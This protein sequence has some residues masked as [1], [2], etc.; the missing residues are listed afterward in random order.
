LSNVSGFLVARS[1]S[2]GTAILPSRRE[3]LHDHLSLCA[4]GESLDGL[5]RMY[6]NLEVAFSQSNCPSDPAAGTVAN[7]G[8]VNP[9]HCRI[10]FVLRIPSR[11]RRQA[12]AR[13]RSGWWWRRSRWQRRRRGA[14]ALLVENVVL[15]TS[16]REPAP[17]PDPLSQL[18]RVRGL[19][20][21]FATA[22][23]T[24]SGHPWSSN[25]TMRTTVTV[26]PLSSLPHGMPWRYRTWPATPHVN[27][28]V[29]EAKCARNDPPGQE[30]CGRGQDPL[31]DDAGADSRSDHRSPFH[32]A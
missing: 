10:E 23:A 29:N 30:R 6:A 15:C 24:P 22:D 3:A 19:R 2:A 32:S 5:T 18:A 17:W 13:R 7:V 27:Q 8:A 9:R 28:F 12:Q 11:R 21:A 20:Q 16:V 31:E 4:S 14:C 25:Q 1:P 26:Q